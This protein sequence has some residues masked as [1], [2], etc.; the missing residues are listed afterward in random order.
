MNNGRLKP[1]SDLYILAYLEVRGVRYLK[2]DGGIGNP[3]KIFYYED[4]DEFKNVLDEYRY[5]KA[6]QI[7]GREFANAVKDMKTI[8]FNT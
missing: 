7:S 2:I 1:I 8:I 3:K 4:T 6:V 5:N